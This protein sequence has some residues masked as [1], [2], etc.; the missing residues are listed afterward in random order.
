MLK[1]VNEEFSEF[2]LI[3]ERK[4]EDET[5]RLIEQADLLYLMPGNPYTQMEFLNRNP[6]S[7]QAIKKFQGIILGVSAGTMNMA[8]QAY[9]LK[10]EGYE[11]SKFYSGLGLTD[12]TVIPH[13]NNDSNQIDLIR[14]SF[15]HEIYRLPE[16]SAIIVDNDGKVK[17]VGRCY[18]FNKG[19]ITIINK[20]KDNVI[21]R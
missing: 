8:K 2:E 6:K 14:D 18:R 4:D 15:N 19:N 16:F 11:E 17:F 12:I 20:E 9:Y 13:F 10:D 7:L 1:S 21:E 3:D 5:A